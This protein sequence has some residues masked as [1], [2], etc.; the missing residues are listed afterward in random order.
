MQTVDTHAAELLEQFRRIVG[1]SRVVTGIDSHGFATD[2]Y[3]A[4]EMPLAVVRPDSVDQLTQVVAAASRAG[5]AVSARGGG[6]SYTG[7]YLLQRSASIVLDLRGLNR[8]VEI[9][10]RD[11]YVTVEAGVTWDALKAALDPLGLRTPFFGPFSGLVA[12]VGGSI[13]QHTIGLGSGAFGLSAHSVLSMQVV[14]ADGSMVRTGAAHGQDQ[15]F[16]RHVGP[17]LTGLFAG[18]CGA[19][20]IKATVTLALLRRKPSV[21]TASFAFAEFSDLHEAMREVSLAGLDDSHFAMDA[22]LSVGE[23]KRHQSLR[24]TIDMALAMLHASS[25][26][27]KGLARLAHMAVAGKRSL[28][29]AAYTAHFIIEGG[30]EVETEAKVRQ[31][32]AI[33]GSYGIEIPNTVPTMIRTMP[34]AK[35]FNTLGPRGERWLPLHGMLRHSRVMAFHQELNA[36]FAARAAEMQRLRIWVGAMFLNAGSSAFVYEITLYWPDAIT[37]YHRLAIPENDLA[38]LPS[39]PDNPE[40]ASFVRMLRADLIDLYASHGAT[41]MQLGKSYPYTRMLTPPALDLV[42]NLKHAVDPDDLMNPGVLGL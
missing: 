39:Y 2:V 32:R 9:N 10:E 15:P 20:G 31:L 30:D 12:T 36:L 7:G 16:V 33:V 40:A 18:D 29:K 6:A 1:S 24:A 4:L 25:S 13:S 27:P 23:I 41:Q 38:K 37:A 5:V 21:H 8:I 19:L 11:A 22:A 42:R 28:Q 26:W 14:L 3:R 17:D 34:F 35:M